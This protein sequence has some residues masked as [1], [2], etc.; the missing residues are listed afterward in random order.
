MGRATSGGNC[1]RTTGDLGLEKDIRLPGFYSIAF[2]NA[3]HF[4]HA[5]PGHWN[6]PDYILIGSVGDALK[7]AP[8]K[9]PHFGQTSNTATCLC[10]R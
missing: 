4:E 10:G 1:W 5:G 3:E 9:P 2:K 8:P 7:M 6:D